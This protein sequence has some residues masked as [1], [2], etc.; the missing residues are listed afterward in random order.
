MSATASLNV[1]NNKLTP[2]LII[3]LL[4]VWVLWG[5]TYNAIK[6]AVGAVPPLMMMGARFLAAGAIL[7]PFLRLRG[8]PN[9]TRKQWLQLGS[10]GALMLGSGSGA[11]AFASQWVSSGLSATVIATSPIWFAIISG[12]M[13]KWP[14]KLE[15]LGIIIGFAGAVMLNVFEGELRGNFVA[16]L[17]LFL[18][19]IGWVGGSLLSQKVNRDATANGETV[20]S[21]PMN[22]AMQLICGGILLLVLS[23]VRGE[24]INGPIPIG[25]I[26]AWGYLVVFGSLIAFSAYIYTLRRA[27]P[28]LVSSYAFVNPIVATTIGVG[29]QGEQL[30]PISMVAMAIVLLG[31]VCITLARR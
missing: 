23:Q 14:N 5:S 27:R 1:E 17:A 22:S 13:G 4:L 18:G 25:A 3:A 10:L 29:L 19:P 16:A 7:Y 6:V 8:T 12:L 26:L 24:R 28:A 20:P 15:W 21:G 31:V 2:Q 9:P 30:S 11:V